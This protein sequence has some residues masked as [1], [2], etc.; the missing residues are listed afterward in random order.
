MTLHPQA[1]RSRCV[2]IAVISCSTLRLRS[3]AL[4][5]PETKESPCRARICFSAVGSAGNLFP[6]AMPVKP[7]LLASARQ[8]SSGVSPPSS[9]M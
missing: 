3:S 6:F 2:R 7:A 4:Y 9:G 5:Q 1:F 8:V